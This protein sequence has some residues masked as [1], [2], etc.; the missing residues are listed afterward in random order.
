MWLSVQVEIAVE[1]V[2]PGLEQGRLDEGHDPFGTDRVK[3]VVEC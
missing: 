2:L 1:V 3:R